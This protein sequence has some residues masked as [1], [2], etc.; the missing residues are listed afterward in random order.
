MKTRNKN[1]IIITFSFNQYAYYI[2]YY[3]FLIEN[4][5]FLRTVF[6]LRSF[7]PSF[8]M[9]TVKSRMGLHL[10]ILGNQF[11]NNNQFFLIFQYAGTINNY[12]E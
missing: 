6:Q 8:G 2:I 1:I 12:I 3:I 4:G 11:E 10:K 7:L 9:K 5:P